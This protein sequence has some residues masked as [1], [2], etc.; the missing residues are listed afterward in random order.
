MVERFEDSLLGLVG[1]TVR[2][3]C[4][5]AVRD[6]RDRLW[7]DVLSAQVGEQRWFELLGRTEQVNERQELARQT[8]V[9]WCL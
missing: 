5:V 1:G 3:W 9:C 7:W 8:P 6:S 2:V 4:V